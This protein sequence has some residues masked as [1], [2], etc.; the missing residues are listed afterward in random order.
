MDDLLTM[1]VFDG[2]G[3]RRDHPGYQQRRSR[4]VRELFVEAFTSHIFLDDER[5]PFVSSGAEDLHDI[6][7]LEPRQGGRLDHE[8]G[9]LR[10]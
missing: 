5:S 1:G 3:E 10:R 7:V 8:P 4:L 2:A 9:P 6:G